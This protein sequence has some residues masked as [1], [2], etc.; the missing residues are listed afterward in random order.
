MG[1]FLQFILEQNAVGLAFEKTTAKNVNKWLSENGMDDEFKASRFK[2]AAGQR[3]EDF[4][5]VYV[6]RKDGGGFFIE[7]K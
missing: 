3:S 6:R 2:P 5:D 7:C 4:P 1:R